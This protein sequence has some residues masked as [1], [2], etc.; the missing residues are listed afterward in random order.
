MANKLESAK[1]E[2][3]YVPGACCN[4]AIRMWTLR[5]KQAYVQEKR[6]DY[7]RVIAILFIVLLTIT[8]A[9]LTIH[10]V[11]TGARELNPILAY[12]LDHSPTFFF[13][14]KYFLTGASIFLILAGERVSRKKMESLVRVLIISYMMILSLVVQ[15]EVYLILR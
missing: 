3:K 6:Y 5:L 12:Y 10:L 15:W 14:V 7:K 2:N 9:F 13:L 8:D 1:V 11:E 4:L